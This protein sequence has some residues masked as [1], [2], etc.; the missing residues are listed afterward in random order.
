MDII[1]SG[2]VKSDLANRCEPHTDVATNKIHLTTMANTI[3]RLVE[4]E[5][6]RAPADSK[7][8]SD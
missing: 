2:Q 8:T 4:S 6:I 7:I 5:Y 3:N 1:K